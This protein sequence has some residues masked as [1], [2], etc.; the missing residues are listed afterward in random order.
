M[1][2]TAAALLPLPPAVSSGRH[3]KSHPMEDFEV[4]A[5][6]VPWQSESFTRQEISKSADQ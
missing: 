4:R 3:I 6:D 5:A 2:G 1:A